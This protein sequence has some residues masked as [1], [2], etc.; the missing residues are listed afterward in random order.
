M[1]RIGV[2]TRGRRLSGVSHEDADDVEGSFATDSAVGF[3]PFPLLEALSRHG[4]HAV[5]MG[6]V[7]GIMHGSTEMTGDLDLLWRGDHDEAADL[8]AAFGSVGAALSDEDGAPLPCEPASFHLPKVLFEARTASGDCC[9]PA[10]PWGELD[11]PGI[12]ERADSVTDPS[13]V[14]IRFVNRRDL[15]LMRRAAGRTKDRR[16]ARELERLADDA[17]SAGGH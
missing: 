11:V 8:A 4:A 15:V 17:G 9:T 3:D 1:R 16:R 2:G 12:I 10:L 5:V 14:T 6:Q 7:A 13:G